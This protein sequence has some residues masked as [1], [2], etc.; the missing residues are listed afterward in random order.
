VFFLS[1]K[2]TEKTY[3]IGIDVSKIELD[4]AVV[5]FNKVLFHLEVSNTKNGIVDFMKRI[6]KTD[7]F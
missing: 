4:F 2:V 3:F 6:K 7:N 5:E 1:F